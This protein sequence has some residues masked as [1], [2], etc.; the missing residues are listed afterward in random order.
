MHFVFVLALWGA[1]PERPAP[2]DR[3]PWFGR[4]KLLHFV[5]SAAV[6]GAAHAAFRARGADYGSASRGAAAVTLTV[7]VSKEIWDHYRG[8][9]ASLR[10]LTWDV[11]GGTAG[12]VVVRQA[13]R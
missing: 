5:A 11:V 6:Q 3:D 10:D 8:G 4:D 13:D 2:S 9:D 12:A 1:P 7:G